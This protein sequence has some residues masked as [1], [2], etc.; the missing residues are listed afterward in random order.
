MLLDDLME[1]LSAT[2]PNA[3]TMFVDAPR[4]RA[5]AVWDVAMHSIAADECMA[6]R[7]YTGRITLVEHMT[8]GHAARDA[9]ENALDTSCLD[10]SRGER[11]WDEAE[12]VFATDYECSWTAP[13]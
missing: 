5:Y 7:D 6:R 4:N 10:W 9:L 12:R 3:E 1:G 8:D 13:A 2:V 11:G